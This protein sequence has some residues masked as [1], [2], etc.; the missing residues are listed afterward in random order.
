LNLRYK[1]SIEAILLGAVGLKNN[2][3]S[4]EKI[5]P[6]KILLEFSI[7]RLAM[8]AGLASSSKALTKSGYLT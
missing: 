8:R 1:N 6:N 3:Q 4:T 7:K 2:E 5:Q